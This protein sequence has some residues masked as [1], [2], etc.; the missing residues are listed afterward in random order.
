MKKKIIDNIG[1]IYNIKSKDIYDTS[2]KKALKRKSE[3]ISGE[4]SD[5][6][7]EINKKIIPSFDII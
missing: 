5:N 7:K 4:E 2:I 1:I 3:N 6:N